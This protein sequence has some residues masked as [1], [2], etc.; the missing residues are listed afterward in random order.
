MNKRLAAIV[1]AA[2]LAILGIIFVVQYANQA[3]ERAFEGAE[4]TKVLQVTTTVPAGS[5]AAEVLESTKLVSLPSAAVPAGAL[6]TL[7]SVG[8]EVTNAELEPGEMVLRSRFADKSAGKKSDRDV[9]P[10]GLQ[11]VAVPLDDSR[12]VDGAVRAGDTVWVYGSF[13]VSG[14]EPAATRLIGSK[15]QVMKVSD[16]ESGGEGGGPTVIVTLAVDTP[17]AEK[18]VHTLE[19]GKVWFGEGNEQATDSG[20]KTTTRKDILR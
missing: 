15:V 5:T 2:V 13:D 3:D 19:F 20:S 6:S 7:D 4:L 14:E 11:T 10:A 12:G 17:T 9:P 8:A 16:S 18:I 1:L